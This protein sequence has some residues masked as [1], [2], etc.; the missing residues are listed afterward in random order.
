[1]D[2]SSLAAAQVE[3][4]QLQ[5]A[6]QS[7]THDINSSLHAAA[8]LSQ[9]A[10][11]IGMTGFTGGAERL[12]TV[13]GRGLLH[14]PEGMVETVKKEGVLGLATTAAE[15]AVVGFGLKAIMTKAAPVAE[16]GALA[17]GTS[18]VAQT[19]PQFWDACAKG[20]SAKTTKDMD[21][22]VDQFSQATGNLAVNS[23]IGVAGFKAGAGSV[24][25]TRFAGGDALG[26][27][28]RNDAL[29]PVRRLTESL[30]VPIRLVQRPLIKL[31]PTTQLPMRLPKWLW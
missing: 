1:M 15:S 23:V 6:A 13:A 5:F 11:E 24:G 16:I 3:S 10:N 8:A 17:L 25:L 26:Y 20:L 12:A 4:K 14:T 18:F 22:A 28:A 31:F 2:Q 7:S 30:P 9:Q 29:V 21:T 19:V 27:A